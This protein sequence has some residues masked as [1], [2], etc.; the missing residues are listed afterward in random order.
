MAVMTMNQIQFQPGVSM[1][2][3]IKKFATE[4]QCEAELEQTVHILAQPE[5]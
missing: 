1:P 3:F 4:E 5:H 2:E